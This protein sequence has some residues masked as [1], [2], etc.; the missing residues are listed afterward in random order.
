MPWLKAHYAKLQSNSP[1]TGLTLQVSPIKNVQIKS[2]ATGRWITYAAANFEKH[3][4]RVSSSYI[5]INHVD[6]LHPQFGQIL[7]L[8]SHSFVK[9]STIICEVNIFD[10]SSYDAEVAMWYTSD[11]VKMKSFFVLEEVSSP[12][13][14]SIEKEASRIWFLNYYN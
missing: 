3:K 6:T 1:L 5:S 9:E 12:L 8:Y 7:R 13:I 14:V 10:S 2:T 4:S 11:T